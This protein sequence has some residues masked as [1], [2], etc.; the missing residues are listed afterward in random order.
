MPATP[1]SRRRRVKPVTLSL[2]LFG[3]DLYLLIE[4]WPVNRPIEGF[5][6]GKRQISVSKQRVALPTEFEHSPHR[7]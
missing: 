1:K 5:E 6:N 7:D 2:A 3:H 4:T